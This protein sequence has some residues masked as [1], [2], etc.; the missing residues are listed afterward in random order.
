MAYEHKDA[1]TPRPKHGGGTWWHRVGS[2]TVSEDGKIAIYLDSYP[3]PD[4]K[5]AVKIM[6]FD[7]K[8]R[9]EQSGGET[10]RR[11]A[12]RKPAPRTSRVD[13]DE[14]PF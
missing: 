12:P 14:I 8:P 7:R 1:C 9:E 10:Q 2:A 13:D 5:G 6:L 4:E 3:V 11:E